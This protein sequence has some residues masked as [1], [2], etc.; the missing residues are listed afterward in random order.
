[1]PTS[2]GGF[3]E[4][5][6]ELHKACVYMDIERFSTEVKV[7]VTAFPI[8]ADCPALLVTPTTAGVAHPCVNVTNILAAQSISCVYN[9]SHPWDTDRSRGLAGS[10]PLPMG[11]TV[12]S[13]EEE[14][15]LAWLH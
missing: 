8:T 15:P 12:F 4:S 6:S 3:G 10:S 11:S 14:L 13:F 5:P 9:T 2:W 7:P 1:M